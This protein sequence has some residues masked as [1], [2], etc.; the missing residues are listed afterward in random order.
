MEIK[1]YIHDWL[2][3]TISKRHPFLDRISKDKFVKFTLQ[4]ITLFS[5]IA[6]YNH[7][8]KC[9]DILNEYSQ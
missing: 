5:Y 9:V 8:L 4:Y 7:I 3:G 1:G 2:N 6:K